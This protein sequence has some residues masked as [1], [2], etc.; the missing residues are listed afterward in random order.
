MPAPVGPGGRLGVLAVDVPA[1][2]HE[3]EL[4]FGWTRPRL[5]GLGVSIAALG[6][7][8]ALVGL[9]AHRGRRALVARAAACLGIGLLAG[10]PGLGGFRL[11]GESADAAVRVD[12]EVAHVT[13]GDID[14][15]LAL[16]GASLD[17]RRLAQD[18]SLGATLYW[19]SRGDQEMAY[20]VRLRVARA[21]GVAHDAWW[22]HGPTRRAWDRGEL[23]RTQTDVRLPDDYPAGPARVS[24]VVER[25]DERGGRPLS[26]IHLG[27]IDVPARRAGA[28]RPRF[29]RVPDENPLDVLQLVS[30]DVRASAP[31]A[32]GWLGRAPLDGGIRPGGALDVRLDWNVRQLPARDVVA[33]LELRARRGGVA[34]GPRAVGEW[35]LPFLSWQVGDRIGQQIRLSAPDDQEPGT[36][37]LV[38]RLASRERPWV[39]LGPPTGRS[40]RDTDQGSIPLGEVVVLR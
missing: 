26:E 40:G 27:T 36:Y 14:R 18:G 8:I 3:V 38:L 4:R 24:M 19:F 1:G 12:G 30:Y 31:F 13:A 28:A 17:D 5:V 23:I 34:S 22:G 32:G 20:N 2:I 10:G 21:D 6:G 15:R 7:L 11:A 37:D 9:P 39:R 35:F 33:S 25:R 29:E 16:A